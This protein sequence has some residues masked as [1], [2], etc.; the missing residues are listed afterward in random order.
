MEFGFSE[1]Q[2]TL[3]LWANIHRAVR[4][5][6]MERNGFR[7]WIPPDLAAEDCAVRILRLSFPPAMDILS[8]AT[9]DEEEVDTKDDGLFKSNELIQENIEILSEDTPSEETFNAENAERLEDEGEKTVE[10]SSE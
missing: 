8:H 3:C 1:D 7:F 9:E 4:R 6:G 5:H 10:D 2:I